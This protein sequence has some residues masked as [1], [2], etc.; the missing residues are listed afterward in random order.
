MRPLIALFVLLAQVVLAGVALAAPVAVDFTALGPPTNDPPLTVDI[1]TSVNTF[2]LTLDGVTF[3]Y[4]DFGTGVDFGLVDPAGVFGTTGGGLFLDFGIPATALTLDFYLFDAFS[5]DG[6]GMPMLDALAALFFRNGAFLDIVTVAA[7]FFAY[8]PATD[9]TLGS[10]FSSLA[11][12]GP[13]FDQAALFFSLDAPIF[14]L[15]NVV[16]EPVPE[17]STIAL[18]TVGL[19]GLVGWQRKGRNRRPAVVP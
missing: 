4:D 8:D 1:T 13:A 16:Y 17:P 5:A 19:V 9:P 3:R 10:A 11:Y 7:D 14:T 18:L 2:G 12:Q 15:D 6:D